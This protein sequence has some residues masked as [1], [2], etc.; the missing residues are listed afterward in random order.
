M[1]KHKFTLDK[2]EWQWKSALDIYL[3]EYHKTE[4]VWMKK[5]IA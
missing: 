5:I 3:R 4:D 1:S 2:A